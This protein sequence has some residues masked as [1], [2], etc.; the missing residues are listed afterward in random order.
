MITIDPLV[1]SARHYGIEYLSN[2]RPHSIAVQIAEV[3]SAKPASV[4]E[5]GVGT[6]IAA[7]ALRG[8]GIGV[9][10]LDVQKELQ[11]DIVGDVRS[12]PCRD[13][14]FDVV[15]CCQVLEHLPFDDFPR[16]AAE[17]R[18]VVG[19]RLV[20]SLPDITRSASLSFGWGDRHR[21]HFE[22]SFAP[23]TPDAAWRADRLRTMGHYWEIGV[24]GIRAPR[25]VGLLE[26]AGFARVRTFRV[27]EL[28]W[29]RFFIA[30][31]GSGRG[32]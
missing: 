23:R 17:L 25:I 9:T 15:C 26:Q 5:V 18:R 27:P 31:T 13:G 4:L 2:G 29:H 20:L 32:R 21:W 10:T 16:A 12:I 8:A 1:P 3:V 7:G 28:R 22:W 11:P 19:D 6:G 30:E 24:D 14:Q